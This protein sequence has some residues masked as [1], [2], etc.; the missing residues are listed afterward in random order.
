MV[1]ETINFASYNM[2]IMKMSKNDSIVFEI[3]KDPKDSKRQNTNT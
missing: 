1:T 3:P 2:L